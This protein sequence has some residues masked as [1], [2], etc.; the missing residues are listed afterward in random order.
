MFEDSLEY[1][2]YEYIFEE[3]GDFEELVK[4]DAILIIPSELKFSAQPHGRGLGYILN[5]KTD[6]FPNG[7][8]ISTSTIQSVVEINEHIRIIRTRNTTYYGVI[9]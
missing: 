2:Q 4:C 1:V 7:A 6:R 3:F 8:E 9:I 5:D